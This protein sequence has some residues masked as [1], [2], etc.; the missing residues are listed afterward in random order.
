VGIG[1]LATGAVLGLLQAGYV[2]R[3]VAG[4]TTGMCGALHLT[5]CRTPPEGT[6]RGNGTGAQPAGGWSGMGQRPGAVPHLPVPL[7][8][9]GAAVVF[10]VFW[11]DVPGRL[12][13]RHRRRTQVSWR[14]VRTGGPAAP[15]PEPAD[16]ENG[17]E[18]AIAGIDPGIAVKGMRVRVRDCEVRLRAGPRG[19]IRLGRTLARTGESEFAQAGRTVRRWL[20]DPAFVAALIE[21]TGRAAAYLDGNPQLVGAAGRRAELTSLTGALEGLHRGSSD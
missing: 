14:R 3:V 1:V 16:A 21:E 7:I 5:G 18:V 6:P 2:D 20:R 8:A 12:R 4:A 15:E 9:G 13:R 11:W 19:T 10:A 17:P